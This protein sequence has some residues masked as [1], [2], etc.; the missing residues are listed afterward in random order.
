MRFLLMYLL[1]QTQHTGV[2]CKVNVASSTYEINAAHSLKVGQNPERQIL[3]E[4]MFYRCTASML[5]C[6]FFF[7]HFLTNWS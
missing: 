4:V 2:C 3:P 7:F 5:K 6:F 1:S